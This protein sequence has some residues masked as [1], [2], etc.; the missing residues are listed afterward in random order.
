MTRP[1]DGRLEIKNLDFLKEG[2]MKHDAI[3]IHVAAIVQ[4]NYFYIFLDY[5]DL[6][7]LET[8]L[9]EGEIPGYQ[10][11]NIPDQSL[12]YDFSKRFPEYMPQALFDQMKNLIGAL[13]VLHGELQVE[14]SPGMYCRHMDLKPDNI[15]IFPGGG[16]VGTWKLSDFGISAFKSRVKA[17][18][19]LATPIP[20][21][22]PVNRQGAHFAPELH[23]AYNGNIPDTK[24]DV[25]SY[26]CIF[27]EVL[28][29]ASGGKKAVHDFRNFRREDR[30]DWFY[31]VLDRQEMRDQTEALSWAPKQLI[32]KPK[33][34][35]WI[36]KLVKV[37][38]IDD[39][40][41][42][43]YRELI[44]KMLMPNFHRRLSSEEVYNFLDQMRDTPSNHE[45][46]ISSPLQGSWALQL[47]KD[48]KVRKWALSRNG[49][50]AAYLFDEEAI[51]FNLE[52]HDESWGVKSK[53][54]LQLSRLNRV[55]MQVAGPFMLVL[56][57]NERSEK[58][59]VRDPIRQLKSSELLTTFSLGYGTA[60][61]P[62][63]PITFPLAL[64]LNRA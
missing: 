60:K 32:L 50:S 15:L 38:D 18:K 16:R 35:C 43:R 7:N 6:G 1:Q 61:A 47:P 21:G 55:E 23:P 62:R 33:V 34:M 2:L 12:S 41:L 48:A 20:S 36:Q 3:S 22:T 37:T 29:F 53:H 11:L 27:A 40:K 64:L 19:D 26:G 52:N 14:G 13:K 56:G 46:V 44:R 51:R 28:A 10:D 54:S 5:A 58:F 39:W 59:E 17:I 25:W 9:N 45:P 63:Q 42:S 4:E 24:S 30:N 49:E 57:Y 31:K 8:F